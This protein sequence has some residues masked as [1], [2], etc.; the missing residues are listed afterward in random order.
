M[1]GMSAVPLQLGAEIFFE[2][3]MLG[4]MS[5]MPGVSGCVVCRLDETFGSNPYADVGGVNYVRPS[6]FEGKPLLCSHGRVA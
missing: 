5:I 3:L 1:G 6:R 2:W 4:C